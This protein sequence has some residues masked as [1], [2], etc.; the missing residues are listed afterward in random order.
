MKAAESLPID[1]AGLNNFKAAELALNRGM[2]SRAMLVGRQGGECGGQG[3]SAAGQQRVHG[4]AG[5]AHVAAPPVR[6]AVQ[7]GARGA[8]PH[9]LHRLGSHPGVFHH[10]GQHTRARQTQSFASRLSSSC[11]SCGVRADLM[12]VAGRRSGQRMGGSQRHLQLR[13]AGLQRCAGCHRSHFS[14]RVSQAALA[15]AAWRPHLGPGDP[16][17]CVPICMALRAFR[18]H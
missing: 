3:G 18:Q 7:P 6:G 16:V 2:E 11:P 1:T 8:P 9:L 17:V 5:G 12:V 4:G 10:L 13:Q 15:A 14:R